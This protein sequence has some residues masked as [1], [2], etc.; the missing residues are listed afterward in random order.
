MKE[1]ILIDQLKKQMKA[2]GVTYS[3][4]ATALNLSL[5]TVKRDFALRNLSLSR[6]LEICDLTNVSLKTLSQ[7]LERTETTSYTLTVDQE[8]FFANNINY[9]AYFDQLISGKTPA[10]LAKTYKISKTQEI[11]YLKKLD[12]LKLIEWG[13]GNKIKLLEESV[14]WNEDGK[15]REKFLEINERQFL[16]SRFKGNSEFYSFYVDEIP[17]H[18]LPKIIEEIKKVENLIE[19]ECQMS[20]YTQEKKKTMGIIFAIRPWNFNPLEEL[21]H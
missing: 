16:N 7:S 17:R 13:P 5:S 9:W 14:S 1:K 18:S 15:L 3:Q 6:F 10:F 2:K 8:K 12:S 19:L 4:V 11:K 20:K 21:S